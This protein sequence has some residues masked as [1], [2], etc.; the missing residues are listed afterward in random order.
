MRAFHADLQTELDSGMPLLV[1][2]IEIT[3]KNGTFIRLSNTGVMTFTLLGNAFGGTFG[4]DLSAFSFST[5]ENQPTVS[6]DTGS[7]VSL[8]LSFDDVSSGVLQGC[9]VRIWFAGITSGKAWELGSKWYIGGTR[10]DEAGRVNIDIKASGRRNRQ[11]YLRTFSP[12]CQHRLGDSGCG[13][14]L[15]TYTD[16]VTVA[17]NP[18]SLV[19]TVTGSAR[20][21]D[22]F[23]NGAI[24]FTSGEMNGISVDVRKWVLS[25][26]TINLTHPLPRPVT[27]GDTATIHAGCDKTTGAAGCT[28]FSNIVRRFAFDHLPDENLSY[29]ATEDGDAEVTTVDSGGIWGT[30]FGGTGSAWG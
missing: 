29:P 23:N 5:G 20:A 25:T 12:G 3:K 22:Y 15:A 17:T 30:G 1:H 6:G 9:A 8:P 10:C 19:L 2:L 27:A 21:N 16:T 24:K 7:A 18:S 28:R 26:G 4:F 13:V 14:N 11:L